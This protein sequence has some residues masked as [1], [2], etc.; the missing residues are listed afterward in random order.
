[1]ES[2]YVNYSFLLLLK[3]IIVS[4]F[5]CYTCT[6]SFFQVQNQMEIIDNFHGD[7]YIISSFK[8]IKSITGCK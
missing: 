3:L 8:F 4:R 7:Y 5:Y 2:C 1:M 6:L